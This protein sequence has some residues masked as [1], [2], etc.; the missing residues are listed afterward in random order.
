[1][2]P[3]YPYTHIPIYL[4]TYIPI[5]PYTYI[6][7]NY[8]TTMATKNSKLHPI[9]ELFISHFPQVAVP[10]MKQ[11]LVKNEIITSDRVFK[12]LK[13]IQPGFP[14]ITDIN[15]LILSQLNH[16]DI[17][18]ACWVNRKLNSMTQDPN[19]WFAALRPYLGQV[20]YEDDDPRMVHKIVEICK[21][22]PQQLLEAALS[23]IEPLIYLVDENARYSFHE[24]YYIVEESA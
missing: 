8:P 17:L 23:I 1:M 3:I 18:A 20:I 14:C 24:H 9:K 12:T 2:I 22:Y 15:I 7:I 10:T 13:S 19:L 21:L 6:H 4:Y 5:Y 16:R 11:L